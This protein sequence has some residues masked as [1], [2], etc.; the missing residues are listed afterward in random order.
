MKKRKRVSEVI[1]PSDAKSWSEGDVITISA[2]TGSGKSY[3]I[4]NRLYSQAKLEGKKI[5]MLIHRTDCVEQFINEIKEDSKQDVIDIKTYQSLEGSRD[6]DLG[7]YKY[8]VSDEFHYFMSD[9]NFNKYTDI[10][11]EKIL[12]QDKAIKIFMSATGKYMEGY[13][14]NYRGME[15]KHYPL[16]INFDFIRSLT[17]FNQY[18]T[19]N[20]IIDDCLKAGEKMIIFIQSSKKALEFHK[21]YKE[22]SLFNCGSGSTKEYKHVNESKISKMLENERFEEQILI[23]TSVMDAGVNIKD[24]SVSCVVV[25]IEDTGVLTQCLGRRRIDWNDKDDKIDIYVKDISNQMLEARIRQAENRIEQADYRKAHTAVEYAEKFSRELD[26]NAIV[27]ADTSSGELDFS[28]NELAYFKNRT[29]ITEKS[30]MKG[31]NG[32]KDYISKMFNTETYT[33]REERDK[34]IEV[35]KY[36][37]A[38]E[39]QIMLNVKDRKELIEIVNVRNGR[40]NRLIRGIGAINDSLAESGIDFTIVQFKTSKTVNGVRKQFSNAWKIVSTKADEENTQDNH[41]I[42]TTK[43]SEDAS[44]LKDGKEC[45]YSETCNIL[46]EE[47]VSE[48]SKLSQIKRWE[49]D[50]DIKLVNKPRAYLKVIK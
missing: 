39:G 10:S 50:M 22:H 35:R 1:K 45:K 47:T 16:P 25:D 15:V 44:Q 49:N 28:V 36:L 33:L 11:L 40:N 46:G 17:F 37:E 9:A 31:K 38:R 13:L 19:I 14:K 18:G 24:K 5:L 7:D 30:A 8:I 4:K 2:G 32:Y 42:T 6:I 48:N 43:E 12:S 3:F 29:D 23:T 21:T 20:N 34:E 27:Y 26:K 41:T